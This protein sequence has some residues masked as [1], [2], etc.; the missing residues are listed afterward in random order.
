MSTRY[1]PVCVA[2]IFIFVFPL[3]VFSAD[4]GFIISVFGGGAG[5]SMENYNSSIDTAN[6]GNSALGITGSLDKLGTC[7]LPEVSICYG[8]DTPAGRAGVYLRNGL[9]VLKES[10]TNVAWPDGTPAQSISGDFS[11]FYSGLGARYDLRDEKGGP[12]TAYLGLD[13]GICHYYSNYMEEE[14]HKIDGGVLYRIKKSWNTAVPG[15]CAEAGMDWWF[16]RAMGLSAKAGYRFA[17][18][19]IMVKIENIEGYTG[20]PEGEDEVDYSGAYI[21]AGVSF[22]FAAA[23]DKVNKEQIMR[24]SQFSEIAGKLKA[25]AEELYAAGF[26]KRAA[27]KA[28]EA[29]RVAPDNEE[30]KELRGHIS[31]KLRETVSAADLG[32]LLQQADTFRKQGDFKKA[33]AL[34]TEAIAV[35]SGN[36]QALYFINE[37]DAKAD[38]TFILAKA[39]KKA[40][41]NDKA[42]KVIREALSYRDGDADMEAFA[43]TLEKGAGSQKAKKRIYN[44]AVEKYRHG[45]YRAAVKLWEEVLALDP[46]DNEV[47]DNIKKAQ[48][49]IDEEDRGKKKSVKDAESEA[50]AMFSIG[51]M[52]AAANKCEYVLRLDPGNTECARIAAEIEKMKEENREAAVIKR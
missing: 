37:F 43:A 31:A 39:L 28:D 7:A 19:R 41:D 52:T 23:D 30:L 15:A 3:S 46:E 22:R 25:E 26:Y 6:S 16:S 24:E 50:K 38:E 35:D 9:T 49:K 12:F 17:A 29:L 4:P 34:Y 44:Q 5:A 40:G 8:F 51:N 14:A 45:D 1:V 20:S 2:V 27:E 10:G 47:K 33:R 13:A 18:G 36:R 42:L 32:R 11:V 48:E 21:S